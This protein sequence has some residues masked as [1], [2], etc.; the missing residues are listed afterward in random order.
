MCFVNFSTEAADS[1][2]SKYHEIAKQYKGEG[3]SFLLGDVE[4]SQGAFQVSV[5]LVY[6]FNSP[7]REPNRFN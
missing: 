4:A 7:V 3:I 2:K 1:I 5:L 6:Y